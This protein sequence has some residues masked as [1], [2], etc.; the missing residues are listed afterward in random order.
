MSDKGRKQPQPR[1][2]FDQIQEFIAGG[3]SYRVW[4]VL[5]EENAE[6]VFARRM[7]RERIRRGW[8]QED[9][10]RNLED[11]TGLKLHPSAIAKIEREHDPDRKIEP[12]VIRLNEALLIAETLNLSLMQMLS[13]DDQRDDRIRLDELAEKLDKAEDEEID[14]RVKA[15][16]LRKRAQTIRTEYERAKRKA[17]LSAT[18]AGQPLPQVADALS[19]PEARQHAE[20]MLAYWFKRTRE[21]L[22][23]GGWGQDG[24]GDWVDPDEV[25]GQLHVMGAVY[26]DLKAL[27]VE[28]VEKIEELADW[29]RKEG[30]D[31]HSERMREYIQQMTIEAVEP[32]DEQHQEKQPPTPEPPF[33]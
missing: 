27:T 19:T 10:A 24:S 5:E 32:A 7:K 2:L 18:M 13:D 8:R 3:R 11:R 33:D 1:G 4:G 14:A 29:W 26:P 28:V 21:D 22:I 17:A 15:D 12:R 23:D 25:I 20:A 31:L 6:R 9:L 30:V 16:E